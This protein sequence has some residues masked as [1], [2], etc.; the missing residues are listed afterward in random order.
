M[1]EKRLR[2]VVKEE[3]LLLERGGALSRLKVLGTPR[4]Q[5]ENMLCGVRG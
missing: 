5:V 4:L 2:L 3:A 1:L